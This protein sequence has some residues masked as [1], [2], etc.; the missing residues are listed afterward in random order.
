MEWCGDN[1][2]FYLEW[3]T[4]YTNPVP[5]IVNFPKHASLAMLGQHPWPHLSFSENYIR[6]FLFNNCLK[7]NGF[8]EI[9]LDSILAIAEYIR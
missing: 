7:M 5:G 4:G 6:D 2:R 3:L 1:Y 8:T 9:D